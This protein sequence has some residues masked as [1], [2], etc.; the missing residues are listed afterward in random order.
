M[1]GADFTTE[2]RTMATC[3]PT[4]LPAI[5][6][7]L[8]EPSLVKVTSTVQSPA[9]WGGVATALRTTRPVISAG[10][11]WYRDVTWLFLSSSGSTTVW[12]GRSASR[13]VVG[14]S[15]WG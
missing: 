9:T 7:N 15:P 10:P 11:S 14:G 12:S 3:L 4:Y 5:A 2:S 8:D 1:V 13:A 6:S